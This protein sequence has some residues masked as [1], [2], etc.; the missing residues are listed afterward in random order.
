[1][2]NQD[3]SQAL[4]NFEK[5]VGAKEGALDLCGIYKVV[6]PILT[7]ILPFIKLLPSGVTIAAAITA[8]MAVLDKTCPGN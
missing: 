7:G 8:L 6:K 5:T 1:M 4:I 3:F 2:A